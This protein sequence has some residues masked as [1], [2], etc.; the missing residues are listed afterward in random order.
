MRTTGRY[1]P[2]RALMSED[3]PQTA[4]ELFS[5][6]EILGEIKYLIRMNARLGSNPLRTM[7]YLKLQKV[8]ETRRET[9]GVA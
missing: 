9:E 6:D 5:D 1:V 7:A 2:G 3:T 4:P 8:L